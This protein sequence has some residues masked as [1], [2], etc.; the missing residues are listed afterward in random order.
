LRDAVVVR[1]TL[2]D[3]AGC[4]L[5]VNIGGNHASDDLIRRFEAEGKP[6]IRVLNVK[7]LYAAYGLEF[8]EDGALVSG[9]EAVYRSGKIPPLLALPPVLVM[10]ASL[11]VIRFQRVFKRR[12]ERFVA[13]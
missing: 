3:R 9:A 1:K 5:L 13:P 4:A 11:A 8:D 7:K 10:L 2:F 6:V 12:G